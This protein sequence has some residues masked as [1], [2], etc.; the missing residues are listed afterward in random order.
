M[1]ISKEEMINSIHKRYGVRFR[2][3]TKEKKLLKI[4]S[5]K[6]HRVEVL[7]IYKRGKARKFAKG[8]LSVLSNSELR[9]FIDKYKKKAPPSG[10]SRKTTESILL[11]KLNVE[12]LSDKELL[13]FAKLSNKA[14]LRGIK[15]YVGWLP[16]LKDKL[17]EKVLNEGKRIARRYS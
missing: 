17:R 6:Y 15:L 1:G 11:G 13:K 3:D 10:I 9:R 8:D 16:K 7:N 4:F 2:K 5:G 12:K 14:F